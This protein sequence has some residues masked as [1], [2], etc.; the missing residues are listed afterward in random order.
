M[1]CTAALVLLLDASA[2]IAPA[3]WRLQAEGHAAAF[4]QDQV[5]RRLHAAPIAV[6]A[7]AFS[8]AP[9][10]MV[11]WRV[12]ASAADAAGFAAELR[13]A[14][15]GRAEGTDIAAAIG[16]GLAALD[17]A[18]CP[19]NDE[20]L[21]LV[22]DGEAPDAPVRAARDEA[23][24]RGV[25]INALGV[26]PAGAGDWLRENAVTAG[27]FAMQAPDWPSFATAIL[28]KITLEIAAAPRREIAAR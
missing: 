8:D 10:P 16:A 6:T 11:G 18:P 24:A 1:I 15:R 5:A 14:P 21:D 22:T 13:A 9:A 23:A 25:R 28:R 2:S 7:I 20:V 3:D 26:G 19:A 4:E 12:L 27:G 17:A